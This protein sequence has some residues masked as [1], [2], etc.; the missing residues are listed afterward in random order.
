MYVKERNLKI[1]HQIST[2]SENNFQKKTKNIQLKTFKE[3]IT[4]RKSIMSYVMLKNT[5]KLM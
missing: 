4:K 5:Y 3:K 2:T 1:I